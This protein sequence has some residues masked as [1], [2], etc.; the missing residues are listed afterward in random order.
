MEINNALQQ[1]ISSLRQAIGIS[2]QR[3]AMNQD[4][5]SVSSLLEG[6]QAASAKAMESSVTPYKGASIDV[7]I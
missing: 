4:A 6:M 2:V 3:K 7:R 1:N 5:Q